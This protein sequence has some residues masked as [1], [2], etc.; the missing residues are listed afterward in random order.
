MLP[1]LKNPTEIINSSGPYMILMEESNIK[2][3]TINPLAVYNNTS[4]SITEKYPN[5]C[6]SI[7][8][9]NI[10]KTNRKMYLI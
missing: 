1:L 8:H 4:G 3:I 10:Y 6:A 2:V 7:R 9:G 5:Y